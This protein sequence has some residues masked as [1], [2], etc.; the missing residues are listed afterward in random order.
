MPVGKMRHHRGS[1][2]SRDLLLSRK[3][4]QCGQRCKDLPA[5]VKLREFIV[6]MVDRR[7]NFTSILEIQQ[8]VK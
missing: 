8:I 7:P 2:L 1:D 5:N 4:W 3:C 6:S